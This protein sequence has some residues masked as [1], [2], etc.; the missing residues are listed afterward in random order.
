MDK[1]KAFQS[2]SS[3]CMLLGHVEDAKAYKLM[4]LATRR[5]F[6]ERIVQFEE[7][8]LLDLPESDAQEG[9]N[10]LPFPF[11]DDILSHVSDLDE[12]EQDQHDLDNEVVPHEDLDLDPVPIP[13]Q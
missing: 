4:E 1:R 8:Q 10:T 3:E 2:Q 13:N 11:D 6:I 7:D 12:E 5:C 9:I